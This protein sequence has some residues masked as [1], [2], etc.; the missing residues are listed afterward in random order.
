MPK[1][2]YSTGNKTAAVSETS[3]EVWI[4][5]LEDTDYL[6][7]PIDANVFQ[8]Y[9]F[10]D[11]DI[12]Q[13]TV[14]NYKEILKTSLAEQV[15]TFIPPSGSFETPDL[16]RYLEL[17][18]SYETSTA[19]LV[20]GLSLADQIRIT[21]SDMKISTICDRYPEI[22]LAEKR[23]YR[24]VAEYLIRQGELT[25]LR[26]SEGKLIKKMG[27][28]QKAVVLYKPLPKLLESLKKS[29]LTHL[30]KK[31]PLKPPETSDALIN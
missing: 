25:K 12:S 21:F 1:S 30:I 17:V 27:N 19:D 31:D 2:C 16:R 23:R 5:E 29:N 10:A 15:S 3:L 28:M 6:P 26:D 8:S 13:V 9:R 22:E 14:E 7:L 11:L 24:C 18:C 4:E 20:L